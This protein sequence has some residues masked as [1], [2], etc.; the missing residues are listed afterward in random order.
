MAKKL[1]HIFS[2]FETFWA[3]FQHCDEAKAARWVMRPH[4]KSYICPTVTRERTPTVSI[5][6]WH[7]C[8][9]RSW[10]RT[11]LLWPKLLCL[12]F[13]LCEELEGAWAPFSPILCALWGESKSLECLFQQSGEKH[14][15]LTSGFFLIALTIFSTYVDHQG[16][17]WFSL[18]LSFSDDN[19]ILANFASKGN[20]SFCR[21]AI[22]EE[23]YLR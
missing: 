15:S 8:L 6:M 9:R 10:G 11:F 13:F 16:R 2:E 21:N 1:S 7:V 19:V 22:S 20:E 23:F 14:T 18:K 5:T 3:I 4:L 17:T 12:R